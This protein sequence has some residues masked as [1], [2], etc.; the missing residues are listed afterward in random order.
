LYRIR[1][2]DIDE[3]SKRW[4]ELISIEEVEAGTIHPI[5]NNDYENK[6]KYEILGWNTEKIFP[7]SATPE[8]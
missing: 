4:V 8:Y 6:L 1:Y 7:T 3:Y 2:F 5:L